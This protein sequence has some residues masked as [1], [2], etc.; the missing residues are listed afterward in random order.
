[1]KIP[2]RRA[3]NLARPDGARDLRPWLRGPGLALA[4]MAAYLSLAQPGICPCWLIKDVHDIHPH[5]AG[6]AD[7]PHSHD[8]LFEM[9]ASAPAVAPSLPAQSPSFFLQHVSAR[10]VWRGFSEANPGKPSEPPPPPTPPPEPP[11]A[12]IPVV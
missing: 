8:Y 5:P 3:N 7:V 12:P 1:M 10:G 9:F 6:H 11:G 4:F 2:A